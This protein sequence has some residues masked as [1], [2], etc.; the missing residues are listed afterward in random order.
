MAVSSNPLLYQVNTRVWLREIS[1]KLNRPA[2]LDDIPD[3]ELGKLAKNGFEWVWLLSVWQTG[4]IGQRLSRT[5][6]EWVSEFQETLPNLKDED[7]PGSGFAIK[8]YVVH[9]KLGGDVA[10]ACLRTR[11]QQQGLKLMLDFVPNHAA[12]DH[13][14]IPKFP[15]YFIRGNETLLASEP[16]NYTKVPTDVG[17]MILAHGRDP[18]FPGWPDTVQFNYGKLELQEALINELIKI[19][20]QCDGIRCDMAMLV[21]PEIF[22]KTWGIPCRSFWPEAIT[23]VKEQNPGFHFMAEVYWDMEWT[24]QQQG[25]DYTYD[26]RL[27]DRLKDGHAKPVREHF[28]ADIDYQQKMVR[29][30]ENHDEQR[31]AAEFNDETHEAAAILTFLSPGLRFFHQGQ[32]EGKKKRISPHLGRGPVEP[33]NEQIQIFYHRL[34]MLLRNSAFHTG[35]WQLLECVPALDGNPNY[36]NYICFAWQSADENKKYIV[37]VNYSAERSHCMLKLPFSDLAGKNWFLSDQFSDVSY[38][39]SGDDLQL[40]GLYLSEPGW[41]YYLFELE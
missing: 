39:R 2:T 16:K 24:L 1:D 38:E 4:E 26:K 20:G 32:L 36:D 8:E 21:V 34:L 10:L 37:V 28:H 14:W 41:K 31:A 40:N 15:E 6:P 30:L 12:L 9:E 22:E 5:N 3:D 18:Y 23:R 27:Y 7:I 25:F 17:E 35:R 33:V 11:L 13:V 19:S 29:F